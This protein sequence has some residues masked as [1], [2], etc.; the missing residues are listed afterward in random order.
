MSKTVSIITNNLPLEDSSS[1]L[2]LSTTPPSLMSSTAAMLPS[3]NISEE[4]CSSLAKEI[5]DTQNN[6]TVHSP[7]HTFELNEINQ[8]IKELNAQ[9]DRLFDFHKP[10]FIT[11]YNFHCLILNGSSVKEKVNFLFNDASICTD[12]K[13]SVTWTETPDK[14]EIENVSI[15]MIN[16][17]VKEKTK[18]KLNKYFNRFYK[19]VVYI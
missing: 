16:Y 9:I 19:D 6:M 17:H 12:W 10:Q 13:S 8:A 11:I 15:T 2:V 1:T 5:A 14:H 18:E 3:L 4:I 7:S